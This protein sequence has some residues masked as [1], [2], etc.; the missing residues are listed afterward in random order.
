MSISTN[1]RDEHTIERP[2]GPVSYR[3]RGGGEAIVFLHGVL[4]SGDLWRNAPPARQR[5]PRARR[6]IIHGARTLVAEDQ[7]EQ[8]AGVMVTLVNETAL[9]PSTRRHARHGPDDEPAEFR[10]PD[11]AR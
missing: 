3:E 11:A 5:L 1:L 8:L 9:G 6:V 7:P 10:T 4:T 2:P